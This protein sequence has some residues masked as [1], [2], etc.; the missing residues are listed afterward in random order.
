MTTARKY[1]PCWVCKGKGGEKEVVIEET[2]EG[3]FYECGYCEGNGLIEINGPIHRKIR[4]EKIATEIIKYGP[5]RE[6][7]WEELQELGEKALNLI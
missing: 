7:T 5:E 2:G 4:A 6:Y 1:F 3:P